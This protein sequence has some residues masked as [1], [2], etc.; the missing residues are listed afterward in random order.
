MRHD[1][2]GRFSF[3]MADPFDT[4]I[5]NEDNGNEDNGNDGTG[6][7]SE[8]SPFDAL[9]DRIIDI[10]EPL[11]E[12]LPPFQ[13]G[14]AG[15]LSYDLKGTLE[16]LPNSV[17]RDFDIPL[18]AFG[19]YDV[20]IAWDHVA[21]R[22]WIISTGRPCDTQ[23]SRASRGQER[24]DQF[25]TILASDEASI[26]ESLDVIQPAKPI[27]DLAPA[28]RTNL[29]SQLYSDQ[30]EAGY[31]EMIARGVEYIHAGDVFQVNLA[32]RLLT[33]A[34]D[35]PRALYQRLRERNPAPFAG[36]FDIGCAQFLSASPERLVRVDNAKVET[37][38]I[39][40]TC[41]ITRQPEADLYAAQ[42]LLNSDKDRSENIMIVDLLRNDLSRVCIPDSVNV[43]QLCELERYEFVQH[44]VSAVVGTLRD[45][46][47]VFDLLKSVFPGGSI[48]GAPKIRAMEIIDELEQTSRGAYCGSLA[49]VGFNGQVDC[50]ILIRTITA[51]QGW[52]QFPVGGGIVTDSIPER[53]F[54]ETW[55]KARG[56]V[57]ALV[58]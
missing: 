40:G 50:N 11:I 52:W 30:T 39:K 29:L 1:R 23:S 48:T 45:G 28:H 15:L 55:A 51:S 24:L 41:P 18:L 38:P 19:I 8:P 33:E 14:A 4:V 57:R 49:Y 35:D 26:A 46:H 10:R 21:N 34:V 20:V 2:L 42:Q 3:L 31:L 7:A 58:P 32:H 25:R 16:R 5:C 9:R 56:M 53:E 43:T 6:K 47:D 12:G 22:A 17:A 13:G 44:L 27:T 54:E 36:Y 37:R